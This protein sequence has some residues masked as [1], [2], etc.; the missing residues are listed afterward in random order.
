MTEA[1]LNALIERYLALESMETTAV[2]LDPCGAS[3]DVRAL[4]V[5]RQRLCEEE[6]QLPMFA[7]H[8]YTRMQEKCAQ[9][10]ASLKQLITAL[11][12][13]CYDL[14]VKI[15]EIEY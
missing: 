5:L 15:P 13:P 14:I 7:T 3:I 2:L 6:L 11:E 8:G 4:P 12:E 10:V 1:M 9:L